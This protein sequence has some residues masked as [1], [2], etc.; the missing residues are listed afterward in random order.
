MIGSAALRTVRPIKGIVLGLLIGLVGVVISATPDGMALEDDVGL[1]WLFN[2]RGPVAPP[3]D[4]V[5]VAIDEQARKE[6]RLPPKP[7]DWPRATHARLVRTLAAAHPTVIVF[8]LAFEIPHEPQGDAQ[9]ADAIQEAGNV[10]IAETLRRDS[11]GQF[12]LDQ[13]ISPIEV[14]EKASTRRA[15]FALPKSSRVDTYWAFIAAGSTRPTLPAMA[16][17]IHALPAY[18]HFVRLWQGGSASPAPLESFGSASHIEAAMTATRRAV[19]ANP[20]AAQKVFHAIDAGEDGAMTARD[21]RLVKGLIGLY[22]GSDERYLNFYGPPRTIRTISYNEL[23]QVAPSIA[24]GQVGNMPANELEGKAIFIGYSALTPDAQDVVRD[25]YNTV[26]NAPSRLRISGVEVAATAFA[27]LLEGNELRPIPAGWHFAAILLWGT[28]LGV[29]ARMFRP[30]LAIVIVAL[31][32]GIYFV[33]AVGLFDVYAWMVPLLIPAAL[34]APLALFGG[35]ALN[36]RDVRKEREVIKQAFGY[37]LPNSVVDQLAKGIGPAK[38][39]NQLVYGACL[40]TD[41]ERYST[42][43]ETMGPRELARLMNDYFAEVFKPVAQRNGVVSDVV[44]DAVL[45]IWASSVSDISLRRN[46]CHAALEI[47]EALEHFNGAVPGRPKLRTR[48]GLHSGELL[49]GSI[50]AGQHFE[51]RAVG[52]IVNTA[53]R[54][55]G[56]NKYLATTVLASQDIVEGLDEFVV[57]PIGS[58]LFA[59]KTRPLTVCE[60]VAR[61][62]ADAHPARWLRERFA[63]ALAAYRGARFD[64]AQARFAEI[65]RECPDDGPSRF[66]LTRAQQFVAA[67]PIGAW[68]WTVVLEKK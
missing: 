54:I 36:Y 30:S 11:A 27:N 24:Q 16:F 9:F 40:Y 8:D 58:F 18:H 14:L 63:E 45:A 55:E 6:L 15:A 49:L 59:G 32:T 51:Y 66:Y 44:G 53:T 10:I 25:D 5:I 46:A 17:Q 23:L 43:S 60:L 39:D 19:L 52:D 1:H 65:L 38:S 12:V 50:G 35:I 68:D 2:L 21:R 3:L 47:A 34:Q 48:I 29:G 7:S 61:K 41:V 28:V 42:I 67:P 26:Y 4:V 20:S 33:I 57:R 64:D 13:R 22:A 31:L 37:F 56:L 62:Q